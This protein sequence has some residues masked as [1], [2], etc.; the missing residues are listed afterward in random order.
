MKSFLPNVEISPFSL[1]G[2]ICASLLVEVLRV[3]PYPQTVGMVMAQ[4]EALKNYNFKG[5]L[6]NFDPETRQLSSHVWINDGSGKE[7]ALMSY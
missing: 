1:E 3:V 2:Y 6:L 5:I 7:W 4:L